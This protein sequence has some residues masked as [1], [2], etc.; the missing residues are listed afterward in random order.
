MI[1]KWCSHFRLIG[2]GMKV[3]H[4]LSPYN[5][6]AKIVR[7]F[8]EALLSFAN[9]YMSAEII[10]ALTAGKSVKM[11]MG[12][13]GITI[14]MNGMLTMISH[15]MDTVNYVKWSQF[16]HKY[17]MSIGR[18]AMSLDYSI[19]ENTEIHRRIKSI[20]DAMKIS[21]YGLIKLHSRIPL[22][23]QHFFSM[24][25][26]IAFTISLISQKGLPTENQLVYF[27]NSVWADGILALCIILVSITCIKGNGKV[28]TEMYFLLGKLSKINRVF[29]YY[30][31][32]YLD[33]HKAGKDI[34]LYRQERLIVEEVEN[35]GKES[36][37]IVHNLNHVVYRNHLMIA[38]VTFLLTFY[39]YAYVGLKAI[40]GAFAIGSVLKYSGAILQFADAISGM[41]DAASQLWANHP[42]LENYFAYMDLPEE[43]KKGY[44][45]TVFD[46][47]NFVLE[48]KNVSFQ[49]SQGEEYVLRNINLSI[50]AG[51]RVAIVGRN[52]SGKSTLIK[53]LCRL[54]EPTE[55]RITLNGIDIREYDYTSYSSFLG[56]VFQDF[57]LFSFS[58]GQNIAAD[59]CFDVNQALVCLQKAG[60]LERYHTLEAGLDTILY[61]DFAA[62]GV[63]VSGGEAQK[64]ALA[65]ALYKAAPLV[66]LD[67]PTAALDPIAEAEI[68]ENIQKTIEKSTAIFVSHRLSSCRF[69]KKIIVMKQG[70]VVQQ[71]AHEELVKITCGEYYKLWQ[72]QAQYYTP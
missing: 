42:Y 6:L 45:N 15:S 17:N 56:V 66:V 20:D 35:F 28:S 21:N 67:E 38:V 65:R 33:S 34:R 46:K 25:F 5:M 18:K 14:G 60:F 8:C 29:D 40:A 19:L 39:T 52:G 37:L 4:E 30:L 24:L 1:K 22:F 31:N 9:L 43:E 70:H 23:F 62:D 11:I 64:I 69:C 3:L 12:L 50:S 68:Y 48:F 47:H 53:L 49:Y 44:L 26:S 13:V 2:R 27:M 72:A 57:N 61:K 63:E 58:L 36:G 7:S 71:G 59:M 41:M 32:Q 16:Y 10:D 55:G 54:Y 51:D